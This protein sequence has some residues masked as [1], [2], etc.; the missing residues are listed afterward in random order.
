MKKNI[1]E[2]NALIQNLEE[3]TKNN[4]L[5]IKAYKEFVERER[6]RSDEQY[7]ISEE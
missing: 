5:I 1:E 6:K 3:E 2:Q 4:N 7:S